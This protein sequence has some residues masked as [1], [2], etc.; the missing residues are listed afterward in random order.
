MKK[1]IFVILSSLAFS[2]N[3]FSQTR[4]ET[5]FQ[6]WNDTQFIIPLNKKKDWNFVLWTF[7]R[8]GNDVK[9]T[10]DARIGGLITKKVNKYV[11]VGGGY[12]YRYSNPTF[13][14]KRYESRYLGMATLTVPLSRDKKWTLVNRNLYQYENRYARPNATVV[15]NRFWVKREVTIA[16]RKF[17]PFVSFETFYDFRLKG[18]ARYRTQAGFSHKFNKRFSADI[19]YVRQDET[20]NRTR[21][22]T[23]NGIGTSFRFNL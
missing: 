20:G 7:G 14:Q 2:A 4:F 21:P 11:T 8:F 16:D 13:R 15:R 3:A 9:T 23:L 5:D 18:F 10:T 19:Y 1:I 12:L 17:E 22:G 6:L